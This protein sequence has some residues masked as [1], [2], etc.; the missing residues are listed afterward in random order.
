MMAFGRGSGDGGTGFVVSLLP[1][2]AA[3][4]LTATITN[5]NRTLVLAAFWAKEGLRMLVNGDSDFYPFGGKV[6]GVSREVDNFVGHL[7]ALHH[8][9]ERG[10]LAI[11]KA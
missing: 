4:R 11:Q 3:M 6:T 7:H 10:V 8:L 9:T 5:T 2:H 1:Q